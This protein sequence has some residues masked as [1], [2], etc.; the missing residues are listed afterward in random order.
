LDAAYEEIILSMN[1]SAQDRI[2]YADTLTSETIEILRTLEK[3][4][5]DAKKKVGLMISSDHIE[6]F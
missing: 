1:N 6:E 3:R 5:E 2:N 4:N